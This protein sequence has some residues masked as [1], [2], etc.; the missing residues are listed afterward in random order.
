MATPSACG[1]RPAAWG[2]EWLFSLFSVG[3]GARR[4]DAWEMHPAGVPLRHV[5]SRRWGE[6]H[7]CKYKPVISFHPEHAAGRIPR[8]KLPRFPSSEGVERRTDCLPLVPCSMG[9]CI[10]GTR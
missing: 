7:R 8:Y 10:G 9:Q 5:T 3:G 2:P 4:E 6:G 1:P